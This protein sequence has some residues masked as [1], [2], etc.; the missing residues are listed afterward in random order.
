MPVTGRCHLQIHQ[1]NTSTYKYI[2][3]SEKN[4]RQMFS[5]AAPQTVFVQKDLDHHFS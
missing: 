1:L 4:D 5:Q 3:F 2:K